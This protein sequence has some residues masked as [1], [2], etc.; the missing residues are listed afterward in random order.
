MATY[1]L[2]QEYSGGGVELQGNHSP[3][4]IT[5]STSEGSKT[6]QGDSPIGARTVDCSPSA[7][8]P[9]SSPVD[10]GD[11][12]AITNSSFWKQGSHFGPHTNPR[13]EQF[14]P[15]APRDL[16]SLRPRNGNGFARGS[17][18]GSFSGS[19]F[20]SSRT[21]VSP[22][23]QHQ[24]E[25]LM[26]RNAMRRLFKNSE[27]AKWKLA[28]YTA[29]KEAILAAQKAALDRALQQKTLEQHLDPID[30][31]TRKVG[32]IRKLIPGASM[33]MTG[34]TSRVLGM[35]TIWCLDWENGKDE[36]APWPSLTEMKWE[37]DDRAKTNCGRFLPLPR[38]QGAANI[39]WHQLHVVEQYVLDRVQCIPTMEDIYA[40]IEEIEE[41]KIPEFLNQ[42]LLEALDESI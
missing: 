34:N 35:K 2:G 33:V 32:S 41:D 12:S 8:T 29:H 4:S 27:V 11:I 23:A 21:W 3:S 26:I 40:P 19:G 18:S 36:I 28:D 24:Q 22:E 5:S 7:A 39:Q 42:G 9:I 6:L 14:S 20:R 15:L 38:E 13:L 31:D 16:G 37:G 1:N 10:G 30:F 25:F 17:S